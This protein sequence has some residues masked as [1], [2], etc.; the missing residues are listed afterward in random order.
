[1][2][3][4]VPDAANP[5]SKET[6]A[7]PKCGSTEPW[8]L[9]SWC[10]NCGYYPALGICTVEKPV[11]L[12][13][14]AEEAKPIWELVPAWAWTLA[15]GIVAVVALSVAGRIVTPDKSW[16][17]TWWAL[18]QCAAGL[19]V[20]SV[21]HGWAYYV[22][23]MESDKF[24]VLDFLMKPLGLWRNSLRKLP[25]AAPRLWLASWGGMA[26][27]CALAIVGGIRYSAI[28]EDWGV[29]GRA[30]HNLVHEITQ[31]AREQ[32]GDSRSLEEAVKDFAGEEEAAEAKAAEVVHETIDCVVI[33]YTK[34]EGDTEFE[35]LLLAS[36]VK[37][38]LE[39]VGMVSLDI[40][41]EV[42]QELNRRLAKLQRNTPFVSCTQAGIWVKPVLA[43]RV[44]YSGWSA[45]RLNQPRFETMLKDLAK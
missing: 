18:A 13:Q 1:M 43:C 35:S 28:F 42:R 12:D 37:E 2:T 36:L 17:R 10:P 20:F 40:P 19:L 44:Q 11:E 34:K 22:A 32:E 38:N 9:A 3:A 29:R 5:E 16:A 41:A 26:A 45:G 15:A 33:G 4:A 7:C 8:G 21:G 27:V 6:S 25:E 31:R 30:Q 24:G 39:Y 14:Q 23:I